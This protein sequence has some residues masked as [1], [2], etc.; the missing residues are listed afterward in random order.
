MYALFIGGN[1]LTLVPLVTVMS[2]LHPLIIPASAGIAGLV[3]AGSSLFAYRR[4][5]GSLVSWQGPL[6]GALLAAIGVQLGAAV[7]LWAVGPNLFSSLAFTAY[8]YLSIGLFSALTAVDTHSAIAEYEKGEAGQ[9]TAPASTRTGA[10]CEDASL[11][12]LMC[13]VACA[14]LCRSFGSRCWLLSQLHQ[15]ARLHR[16]HHQRLP[17]KGLT[18]KDTHDEDQRETAAPRSS[19][20]LHCAPRPPSLRSALP[21]DDL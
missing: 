8:P 19:T 6:M 2:A 9:D 15:S 10:G 1:A 14:L 12:P 7:A 3:M 4:P 13:A 18:N 16:A 20:T 21:L 17:A 5:S 11:S